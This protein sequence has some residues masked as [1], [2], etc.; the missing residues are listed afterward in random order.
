MLQLKQITFSRL[1]DMILSW[2]KKCCL[3]EKKNVEFYFSLLS[4]LKQ[5]S[6][7]T[8]LQS[9]HIWVSFNLRLYLDHSFVTGTILATQT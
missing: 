9:T 4:S 2:I 5:S 6:S 7:E 3:R 1:V 8:T